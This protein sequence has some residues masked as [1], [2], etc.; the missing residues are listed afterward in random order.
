M[1]DFLG[2]NMEVLSASD[3]CGAELIL[4]LKGLVYGRLFLHK[5]MG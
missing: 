1:T 3:E 4:F 5:A 2:W